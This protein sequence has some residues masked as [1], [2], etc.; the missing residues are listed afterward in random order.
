[1]EITSTVKVTAG[2]YRYG[3]VHIYNGG[4]LCFEDERIDFWAS[5][6]LIENTGSLTAGKPD[7]PIGTNNGQLTIH[8]YGRDQGPG[9]P[10]V[11]CKTGTRCGVPETIWNAGDTNKVLLPGGVSDY[12]YPYGPLMFDDPNSQTYFGTK[13]LGVSYGGSLQLFGKKAP[14]SGR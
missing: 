11:A 5:A 7:H 14:V 13:V 9:E 6:I 4:S 12:F 1:M 10:G 8:L 3:D 2:D